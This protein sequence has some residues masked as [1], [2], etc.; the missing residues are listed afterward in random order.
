MGLWMQKKKRK[1]IY[2]ISGNM[3]RYVLCVGGGWMCKRGEEI[4]Y[5]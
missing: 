2:Q 5:L 1:I 3:A 4:V